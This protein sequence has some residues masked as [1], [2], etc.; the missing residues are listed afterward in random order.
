MICPCCEG[1]GS[2]VPLV[3][4]LG[5]FRGQMFYTPEM[6]ICCTLCK[7]SGTVDEITGREY[8]KAFKA[9]DWRFWHVWIPSLLA[10]AV[11]MLIM[12]SLIT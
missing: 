12:A 1:M 11:I 5:D 2:I 6:P 7:G 9:E 10:F 3:S 8:Q 4:P